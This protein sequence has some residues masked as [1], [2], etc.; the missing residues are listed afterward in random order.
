M[1]WMTQAEAAT[2]LRCSIRTIRRRIRDSSLNARRDGRNVLVEIPAD[3]DDIAGAASPLLG[4][5]KHVGPATVIRSRRDADKLAAM[6][7]S[8]RD[9]VSTLSAARETLET[10]IRH[11]RRSSQVG[12]LV[13]FVAV[14]ALAAVSWFFHI[15][16]LSNIAEVQTLREVLATREADFAQGLATTK[17]R[18][19]GESNAAWVLLTHEQMRTEDLSKHS[20]ALTGKLTDVE[21]QRDHLVTDHR[22]V[23]TERDRLADDLR[24]AR[25]AARLT[26]TLKAMWSVASLAVRQAGPAEELRR[27]REEGR[28]A[29]ARH[30]RMMDAAKALYETKLASAHGRY[31]GEAEELRKSLEHERQTVN[32]L[33]KRIETVSDKLVEFATDRGRLRLE[34]VRLAAEVDI[35]KAAL[36][37]AQS[38]G[39]NA[40]PDT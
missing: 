4:P 6:S 15:E 17:A 16:S 18:Y 19:D 21:N 38:A 13:A 7:A 2:S 9:T 3:D 14:G 32:E 33:E 39:E 11:A 28:L 20:A 31:E 40:L 1:S 22:V 12:W 24:I 37:K 26:D 10:Q 34:Q 25:D 30:Q 29:K 23:A 5:L 27:L 36:E 35:A 8:L